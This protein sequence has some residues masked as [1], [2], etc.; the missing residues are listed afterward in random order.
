MADSNEVARMIRINELVAAEADLNRAIEKLKR[1]KA[2]LIA[3]K[4]QSLAG[5]LALA[6]R[7]VREG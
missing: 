2:P 6:V 4:A 3:M 5:E 1:A 7:K